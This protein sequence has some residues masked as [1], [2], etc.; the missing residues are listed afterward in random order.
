M[1][2]ELTPGLGETSEKTRETLKE[3]LGEEEYNQ[4]ANP[5]AEKPAE[6]PEVKPETP[7]ETP[8]TAEVKQ[9]V[10]E[11]AEEPPTEEKPKARR[12][13]Y[14]PVNKYNELRKELQ[15]VKRQL[16]E[17]STVSPPSV[18]DKKEMNSSLK[19]LAEKYNLD[20]NFVN[21]FSDRL[22]K[23]A[24]GKVKLP[25]NLETTIKSFQEKEKKMAED[26]EFETEFE[27]KIL[28]NFPE[29][30]ESKADFKRLAF[31]E[32]YE[33]TPL[34]VLAHYFQSINKPVKTA[35]SPKQGAGK[36]ELLDF[37]NISEEQLKSFDDAK[38]E[39]Y[40]TWIKQQSGRYNG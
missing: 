7:I 24:E 12:S 2:E 10:E 15:E 38:M 19:D 40:M 39:Q 27:D 31:T 18:E 20:E 34:D 11:P 33:T 16:D 3:V 25:E 23:A 1:S 32:G 29:L 37:K 30:S 4:L 8:P 28:P 22:L 26:S 13:D 35:E 21:E 17:R 36:T 5:T 14:V 9:E 6:V